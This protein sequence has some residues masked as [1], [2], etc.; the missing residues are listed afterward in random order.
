MLGLPPKRP[1]G[2][3]Q[4]ASPELLTARAPSPAACVCLRMEK[5]EQKIGVPSRASSIT[6]QELRSRQGGCP[7]WGAALGFEAF[8]FCLCL[9]FA[10]HRGA[11]FLLPEAQPSHQ[12]LPFQGFPESDLAAHS[13]VCRPVNTSPLKAPRVWSPPPPTPPGGLSLADFPLG[14][15]AWQITAV[16][17]A[18]GVQH[19]L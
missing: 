18:P 13:Q 8:C 16:L 6:G 7:R 12:R 9:F 1:T 11:S 17:M 14:A 4:N 5:G 19:S 10:T 2:C 3:L 15:P